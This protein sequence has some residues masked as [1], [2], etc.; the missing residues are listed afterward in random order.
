MK[1]AL[2][3]LALLAATQSHGQQAGGESEP[4][5]QEIFAMGSS[6]AQCS[7]FFLFASQVSAS[8][9][10]PAAADHL[11]NLYNGWQVAGAFFLTMGS[12]RADFNASEQAKFIADA[13][14]SELKAR[15]ELGGSDAMTA[16]SLEHEKRCEP[17][18]DAKEQ[19]IDYL[20][21]VMSGK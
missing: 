9:G 2:S 8:A 18:R 13:R 6:L 4:N 17:L 5:A 12:Q 19:T 1:T 7:A 14:L 3:A 21:R 10:K 20:R 16:L 11:K 15:V